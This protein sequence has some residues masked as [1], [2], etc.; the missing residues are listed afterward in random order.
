MAG[1]KQSS[2][3]RPER[4]AKVRCA[5][6]IGAILDA[7]HLPAPPPPLETSV[8]LSMEVT[9]FRRRSCSSV[10]QAN[11]FYRSSSNCNEHNQKHEDIRIPYACLIQSL[12]FHKSLRAAFT[13]PC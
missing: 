5:M 7:A 4:H 10:R 9:L 12:F 13:A 8:A 2:I 1:S 3:S 6:A 11:I